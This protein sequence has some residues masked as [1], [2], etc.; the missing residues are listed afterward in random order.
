[1][2]H[3]TVW[4][5]RARTYVTSIHFLSLLIV[6]LGAPSEEPAASFSLVCRRTADIDT[7]SLQHRWTPWTR[8]L[9]LFV[10]RCLF[11]CCRLFWIVG[12]RNVKLTMISTP[13]GRRPFWSWGLLNEYSLEELWLRGPLY[14]SSDSIDDFY[15]GLITALCPSFM[16]TKTINET[17]FYTLD[18]QQGW[19]SSCSIQSLTSCA[20]FRT[21]PAAYSRCPWWGNL[22]PAGSVSLTSALHSQ[23]WIRCDWEERN[24]GCTTFPQDSALNKNHVLSPPKNL[25]GKHLTFFYYLL[26]RQ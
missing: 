16:N 11:V 24:W 20:I 9:S 2:S 25:P 17:R 4:T 6:A 19:I 7:H 5:Q 21:G 13:R 3:F 8:R 23:A 18:L 22:V 14:L 15:F 10:F 1:M 12:W 26:P